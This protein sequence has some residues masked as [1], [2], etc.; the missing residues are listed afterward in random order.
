MRAWTSYPVLWRLHGIARDVPFPPLRKDAADGSHDT[1]KPASTVHS[2][3]I[4][5]HRLSKRQ[6]DAPNAAEAQVKKYK[7]LLCDSRRGHS[8][9]C[10]ATV[11]NPSRKLRACDVM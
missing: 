10:A 2:S 8:G 5:R 9:L 1:C 6:R 11:V 3:G 4:A 7:V